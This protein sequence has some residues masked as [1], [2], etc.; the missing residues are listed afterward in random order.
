MNFIIIIPARL[1]STRFP[2]KI[3]ANIGGEPMIIRTIGAAEQSGAKRIIVATDHQKIV[4]MLKKRGKE[5]Y[6]TK[7]KHHSGTERICEI[8]EL[9]KFEDDQII[10]NLQADEPFIPGYIIKKVAQLLKFKN[11]D[12]TTLAIPTN[13]Q[14]EI[15]NPNTVKVITDVC[16]HA[17]YFSRSMIPW[18]KDY[19]SC[20]GFLRHVGIYAY[21]AKLIRLYT[22]LL[23]VRIEKLENLEQLRILWYRKKMYV[24]TKNIHRCISINT[25]EDLIDVNKFI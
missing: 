2:N 24:L 3:L 19:K 25:P 14:E 15:F 13:K 5:V 12:V 1:L 10:V 11:V 22:K 6:I 23:P 9:L 17:L 16:G 7:K 20:I 4:N 18:C 8:I 21:H